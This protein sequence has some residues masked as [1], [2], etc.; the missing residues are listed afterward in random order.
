MACE[1]PVVATRVGSVGRDGCGWPNRLPRAARATAHGDGRPDRGP[2]WPIADRADGDGSRRSRAGHRPWSVDR[3]VEGYQ[4]LIAELYAAKCVAQPPIQIPRPGIE[5]RH[6]PTKGVLAR[7]A[8]QGTIAPGQV[9]EHGHE[10]DEELSGLI[11]PIP[12]RGQRALD[13]LAAGH[14]PAGVLRQSH[15]PLGRDRDLVVAAARGADDYPA[16]GRQ[17]LL[18][19]GTGSPL[20]GQPIVQRD[21]DR[22]RGD[23]GASKPGRPDDPRDRPYVFADRFSGRRAERRAR[24]RRVQERPVLPV[25]EAARPGIDPRAPRQHESHPAARRGVAGA[26][27]ELHHLRPAAVAGGG[28]AESRV[29][30]PGAARPCGG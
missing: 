14:L 11:G 21:P 12:Q 9:A 15:E 20:P 17:G 18:E 5:H 25:Q 28:R 1:K 6:P 4:D 19:Q 22:P 8:A 26:D 2:C 29:P 13:R 24:D 23:Q 7:A 3:M 30:C 16:R 27:V 10:P